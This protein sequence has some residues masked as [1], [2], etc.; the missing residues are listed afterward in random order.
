MLAGVAVAIVFISLVLGGTFKQRGDKI[1][2][3][4]LGTDTDSYLADAGKPVVRFAEITNALLT[5]EPGTTTARDNCLAI[6]KALIGELDPAIL[7]QTI[8]SV[9]DGQLANL[10]LNDQAA[11]IDTLSPCIDSDWAAMTEAQGSAR[12]L[13]Q[14]ISARQAEVRSGRPAR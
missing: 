14:L 12:Q 13:A 9:P 1:T 3:A 2:I 4:R 11:R 6:Q 5:I 8:L 7:V 10:W